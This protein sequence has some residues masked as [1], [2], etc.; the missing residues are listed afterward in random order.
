[1]RHAETIENRVLV[2]HCGLSKEA[3]SLRNMAPG[4]TSASG[5]RISKEHERSNNHNQTS[6][7][8]G[9]YFSGPFPMF[10]VRDHFSCKHA[11]RVKAACVASPMCK[12]KLLSFYSTTKLLTSKYATIN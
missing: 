5:V 7:F 4:Q 9:F 11:P 2:E 12:F 6:R 10:L 8:L 1:M 3:W